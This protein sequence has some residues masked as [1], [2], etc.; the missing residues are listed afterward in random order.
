MKKT[1]TSRGNGWALIIPKDLLKLSGINPMTSKLLFEYKNKALYVQEAA[2]QDPDKY[3]IRK[4][5]H[6][7]SSWLL[8]M[9]NS[10]LGLLDVDPPKD[11]LDIDLDGN[12]F[13]IRKANS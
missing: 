5:E 9:T 6:K 11:L 2:D 3:L 13:I 10:I 4:L 12:V 8:Y 1:L 7:G